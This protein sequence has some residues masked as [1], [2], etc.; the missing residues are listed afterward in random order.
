MEEKLE[1]IQTYDLKELAEKTFQFLDVKDITREEYNKRI[2][3]FLE[4]IKDKKINYNT[5]REFKD[6]L[7]QR[8]DFTISTKNKYLSTARVFL[9]ELH[10][11]GNI[12]FDITL[13]VK[14][15]K[16]T[17]KHKR[18]GL[19]EEE[20]RKVC[21]YLKNQNSRESIREGAIISLLLFQGLRQIEIIR[22]DV[23]DLNLAEGVAYIQGKGRDDKEPVF[24]HKETIRIL[25]EYLLIYNKKSGALFTSESNNSRNKRISTR[26][27]RGIVKNILKTLSIDK[28]THG[29]RHFFTT[30]LLKA[31][32]GDIIKVASFTRHK[33]LEMLQIYN[34][35]LN[36]EKE[37]PV[38]YEAFEGI[39]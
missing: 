25:K 17:K 35:D 33:S 29:F 32:K 38:Y 34:D 2:L 28:T 6:Y 37:L 14:S 10:R 39:F 1:I 36:F 20:I 5:F 3:L 12:P 31:F 21:E 26:T 18:T 23:E 16:Q 9:K 7:N 22:L 15:F 27:L 19:N 24:L 30:N 13:N 4:F 8:A 11:L